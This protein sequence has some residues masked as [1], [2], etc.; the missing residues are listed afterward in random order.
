MIREILFKANVVFVHYFAKCFMVI[1]SMQQT[2]HFCTILSWSIFCGLAFVII[3]I[4]LWLFCHL[5]TI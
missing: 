4:C 1:V 5:T 2:K 3:G